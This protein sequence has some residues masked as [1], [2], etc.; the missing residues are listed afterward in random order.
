MFF[1]FWFIVC[2][3]PFFPT[4][5]DFTSDLLD[6]NL[7]NAGRI[8]WWHDNPGALN[9][10]GMSVI[11]STTGGS[12]LFSPMN[13]IYNFKQFWALTKLKFQSEFCKKGQPYHCETGNNWKVGFHPE[14]IRMARDLQKY[15]G[16]A[17]P[18]T[19]GS[20]GPTWV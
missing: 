18:D 1:V 2:K 20:R 5:K 9:I 3:S 7:D 4:A 6:P 14:F 16:M 10:F 17:L 11:I 19:F 12:L 8:K 15:S 13:T